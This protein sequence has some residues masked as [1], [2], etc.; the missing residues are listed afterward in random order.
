MIPLEIYVNEQPPPSP[1]TDDVINNYINYKNNNNRIVR[2]NKI[3]VE[4]LND[5]IDKNEIRSPQMVQG[6][7]R[8]ARLHVA[9]G[10]YP[11]YYSIARVNGNFGKYIRAFRPNEYDKLNSLENIF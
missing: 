8:E 9:D 6:N 10:A 1:N 11:V 5:I 7:Y 4:K 2:S 3:S